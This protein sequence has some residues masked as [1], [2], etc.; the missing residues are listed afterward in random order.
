MPKV[1]QQQRN[2]ASDYRNNHKRKGKGVWMDQSLPGIFTFQPPRSFVRI[3]RHGKRKI[4]I[5]DKNKGGASMP[6]LRKSLVELFDE[7]GKA[8][9]CHRIP[10]RS[11]FYKDHQFPVCARCT[12]VCI[13]QALAL[14]A[15]LFFQ[16]PLRVSILFLAL[17]GTDWG[18]QETGLL[19]S[20]NFRRL[21]TGILGG[22]GLFN[23]YCIM[24]RKCKQLLTVCFRRPKESC[25]LL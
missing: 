19:E 20:T 1:P 13:G 10:Q 7:L 18:I 15:N 22:F 4:K 8:S 17:M 3:V 5:K 6:E 12:G 24:T 2:L 14:L 16:I 21:V 25:S 23:F 11:F 9:G